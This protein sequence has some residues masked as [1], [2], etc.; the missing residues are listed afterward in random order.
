MLTEDNTDTSKCIFLEPRLCPRRCGQILLGREYESHLKHFCPLRLALCPDGCGRQLLGKD[1]KEHAKACSMIQ[2]LERTEAALREN[3]LKEVKL[4]LAEVYR[5]KDRMQARMQSH[6]SEVLGKAGWA[7]DRCANRV[8]KAE[9]ATGYLTTRCRRKA[10]E[11]MISAL[12]ESAEDEDAEEKGPVSAQKFLDSLGSIA[13]DRGAR[14]WDLQARGLDVLLEALEEASIC[15]GDAALRQTCEASV[16]AILR[17]LLQAAIGSGDPDIMTEAVE[18]SEPALQAIELLPLA[19][20]PLLLADVQRE[21]H[22]ASLR[23]V[24]STHPAFLML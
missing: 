13:K 6:G 17:R 21:L 12:A 16:I 4:G 23:E 7:N 9:Y 10:K 11:R 19:D 18:V 15:C 8:A 24:P 1:L 5:E 3:C 22:R 14:P 2:V 20:L